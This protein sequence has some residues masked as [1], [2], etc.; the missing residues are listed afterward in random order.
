MTY[1]NNKYNIILAQS[2]LYDFK[3]PIVMDC[4]FFFFT[5]KYSARFQ[6]WHQQTRDINSTLSQCWPT[7]YDADPTLSQRFFLGGIYVHG[8]VGEFWYFS[9]DI[10][11]LYD[12]PH[13]SRK[14]TNWPLLYPSRVKRTFKSCVL[15]IL[16]IA[17]L[18]QRAERHVICNTEILILTLSPLVTTMIVFNRFY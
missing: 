17:M 16:Y 11:R 3:S 18:P 1:N 15:G 4:T 9:F 8:L 2:E 12:D 6:I 10:I 5:L 7:V 13:E 14:N